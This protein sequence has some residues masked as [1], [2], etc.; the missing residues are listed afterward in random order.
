TLSAVIG[1]TNGFDSWLNARLLRSD[2]RPVPLEEGMV[3]LSGTFRYISVDG[4]EQ[5][6]N[7][8][9]RPEYRKGSSQDIIIPLVRKLVADGEKVIVFRET[10][11]ITQAT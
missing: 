11:P 7:N 4:K 1:D 6:I 5:T 2:K 8:Y 10:K 9:V 3:E